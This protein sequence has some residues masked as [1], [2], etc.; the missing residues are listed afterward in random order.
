MVPL[1]GGRS[2]AAGPLRAYVRYSSKKT[3]TPTAV[4]CGSD[5]NSTPP[6][7]VLSRNRHLSTRPVITDSAHSSAHHEAKAAWAA[8]Q[9]LSEGAVARMNS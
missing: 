6:C 2:G 1:L 7:A 9:T 4:G 3:L 8:A 5:N